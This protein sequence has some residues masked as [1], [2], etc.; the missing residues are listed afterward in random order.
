[1]RWALRLWF[2]CFFVAPAWADGRSLGFWLAGD[3]GQPFLSVVE[4]VLEDQELS[5]RIARIIDLEGVEIR[6]LCDGCPG[7]MEG[8][9]MKGLVF[10]RGLRQYEG[11]WV[12]GTIVNL[13]PGLLRGIEGQCELEF[14][15]G[16]VELYGYRTLFGFKW[17]RNV[18]WPP[19]GAE[20]R[21]N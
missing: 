11:R 10:I 9:P 20:P 17:G 21:A 14:K 3:D 2:S 5:G 7:D 4:L 18:T 1:M 12:D 13:E 19:Y 6:S 15:D 16:N 8:K